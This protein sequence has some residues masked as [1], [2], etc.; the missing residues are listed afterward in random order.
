MRVRVR[1]GGRP[2]FERVGAG[3]TGQVSSSLS[4]VSSSASVEDD[5]SG[6]ELEEPEEDTS[7]SSEDS[8]PGSTSVMRGSEVCCIHGGADR[9]LSAFE[10]ML[11]D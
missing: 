9:I 10:T 7:S 2:D 1:F 3:P 8:N 6:S 11:V 5:L 4:V